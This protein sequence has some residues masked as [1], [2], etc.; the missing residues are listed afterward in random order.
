MTFFE[1]PSSRPFAVSANPKGLTELALGVGACALGG[2]AANSQQ[3]TTSASFLPGS[4]R[5]FRQRVQTAGERRGAIGD[6]R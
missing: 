1:L 6:Q 3:L 4:A 2:F 5:R